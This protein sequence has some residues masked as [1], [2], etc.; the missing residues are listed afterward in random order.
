MNREQLNSLLSTLCIDTE[1]VRLCHRISDSTRPHP[2]AVEPS[3]VEPDLPLPPRQDVHA[4]QLHHGLGELHPEVPRPRREHGRDPAGGAGGR[5]L[6]V[7][8][9]DGSAGEH[10]RVEGVVE[11][12]RAERRDEVHGHDHV[13]RLV[14]RRHHVRRAPAP[15]HGEQAGVHGRVERAGAVVVVEPVHDEP[16][17]AEPHGMRTCHVCFDFKTSADE[18]L[19]IWFEIFDPKSDE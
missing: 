2:S 7:D 17:V 1:L 3:T 19:P 14:L 13:A 11:A 15:E 5:E 4:P 8:L 10:A 12:E 18:M 9:Q 16:A 6:L